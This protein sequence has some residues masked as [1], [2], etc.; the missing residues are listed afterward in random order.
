MPHPYDGRSLKQQVEGFG[1]SSLSE[2]DQLKLIESGHYSS[3]GIRT[4]KPWRQ[5]PQ[6]RPQQS[7]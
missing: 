3:S 6:H 4:D 2:E 5:P 1:C 7:A